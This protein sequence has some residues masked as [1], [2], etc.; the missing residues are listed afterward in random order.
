VDEPRRPGGARPDEQVPAVRDLRDN[1][2]L[3][4]SD[5][6]VP[7]IN[8]SAASR[9]LKDIAT[10]TPALKPVHQ[11]LLDLR[12]IGTDTS[13]RERFIYGGHA[14]AV[15][16]AQIMIGGRAATAPVVQADLTRLNVDTSSVTVRNPHHGNV[17]T[18]LEGQG[19]PPGQFRL[20]LRE[21]LRHFTQLDS[22]EVE[23]R[24]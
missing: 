10:G 17:P 22:G 13:A 16:G 2:N 1:A 18:E 5:K 23:R 20:T 9:M 4:T 11:L 15:V 24:R 3:L 7:Q 14:Y 12:E 21:F 6:L 8:R 19:Q